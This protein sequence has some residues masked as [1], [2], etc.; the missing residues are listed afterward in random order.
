MDKRQARLTYLFDK[1]LSDA[2]T[3]DELEEFWQLIS[4]T[5]DAGVF[6][7]SIKNYWS[8][9]RHHDISPGQEGSGILDQVLKAGRNNNQEHLVVAS[10]RSFTI[11]NRCIQIAASLVLLAGIYALFHRMPKQTAVI[12]KNKTT[13]APGN[14]VLLTLADGSQINLNDHA[15]GI[16]TGQG[17]VQIIKQQNGTLSYQGTTRE[18]MSGSYNTITTPP[19]EQ[20]H[21]VLSDGTGVWLNATS[22][23]RFPIAFH[24]NT[25]TV[26]VSGEAFFEVAKHASQPFIVHAR[27]VQVQVL[28][29]AFNIMAYHDEEAVKTTLVNGAVEVVKGASKQLIKPGQQAVLPTNSDNI[30]VVEADM[31]EVLAW[32]EGEFRFYNAELTSIMRQITRWY[33][34]EIVYQ[35]AIPENRFYGVIPRQNNVAQLLEILETTHYVHFRTEGRKIIVM[36]GPK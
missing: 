28:G 29:T 27:N 25:R 3:N 20:Y 24:H 30:S 36:Q 32:K 21:I 15:N 8:E 31:K 18:N 6:P 9:L 12:A 16:V 14:Q 13:A 17:G 23:I 33:D 19:G 4:S 35:G 26:E 10:R 11:I 1:Y 5:N 22:S 7:E 2:I 34:V